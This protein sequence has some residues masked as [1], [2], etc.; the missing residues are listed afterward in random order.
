MRCPVC[1]ASL[2]GRRK[3]SKTCSSAC[4]RE[5]SRLRAVLAGRGDGPYSTLQQLAERRQRRANWP[6]VAPGLD[7]EARK[8]CGDPVSRTATRGLGV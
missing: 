3:Q 6:L 2:E 4:R 7:S 5:A 1:G 8:T